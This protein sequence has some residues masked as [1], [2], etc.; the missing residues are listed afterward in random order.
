MQKVENK[1]SDVSGLIT[2]TAFNMKLEKL[3]KIIDH[4]KYVAPW[5]AT[6]TFAATLKPVTLAA[7]MK[8]LIS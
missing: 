3:K 8:L 7:K 2:N 5:L 1:V 4:D 6:D